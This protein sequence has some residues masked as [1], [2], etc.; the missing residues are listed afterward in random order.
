MVVLA[1]IN[2]VQSSSRS[3]T[4]SWA[5]VVVPILYDT[6]THAQYPS[7]CSWSVWH[8]GTLTASSHSLPSYS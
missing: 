2:I 8:R 1:Q 4:F 3:I 6:H 5:T 7:P